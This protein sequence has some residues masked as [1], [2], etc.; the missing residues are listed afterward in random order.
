MRISN[1][2]DE[3]YKWYVCIVWGEEKKIVCGRQTLDGALSYT[4]GR[5]SDL[6][7]SDRVSLLE[8]KIDPANTDN[9]LSA[10]EIFR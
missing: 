8:N 5:R 6:T 10:N 2:D 9:W 7:I 3:S 1:K 4:L